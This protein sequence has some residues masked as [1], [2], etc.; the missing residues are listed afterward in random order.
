MNLYHISQNQ[1]QNYDTFDSAVV[2]AP[3]QEAASQTHPQSSWGN[4]PDEECWADSWSGWCKTPADVT[5]RL[6]GTALEGTVAGV[7]C[8]SYNAG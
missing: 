3:N 4:F 5:V 2:A 1:N 6:L 7:I 8:A